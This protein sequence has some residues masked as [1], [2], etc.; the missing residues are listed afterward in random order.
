MSSVKVLCFAFG[1]GL[2]IFASCGDRNHEANESPIVASS[3]N[4][5]LHL[6]EVSSFITDNPGLELSKIQVRNYIQR[7]SEKELIYQQALTERRVLIIND[8]ERQVGHRK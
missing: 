4:A 1:F 7:W 5:K 8:R 3:G 6:N 2:L